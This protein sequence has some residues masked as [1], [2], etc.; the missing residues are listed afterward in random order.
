VSCRTHRT[1]GATCTAA[2]NHGRLF[3]R[4]VVKCSAV[5]V[6][7]GQCESMQWLCP[8]CPCSGEEGM[9]PLVTPVTVSF[10]CTLEA[11]GAY[12]SPYSS[13]TFCGASFI[14]PGGDAWAM[15]CLESR[16]CTC[17]HQGKGGTSC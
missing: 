5:V 14:K 4:V 17:C 9:L 16:T 11:I 7:H 2:A 3:G 12:G 1:L 8:P 6:S 15:I 13:S 10:K